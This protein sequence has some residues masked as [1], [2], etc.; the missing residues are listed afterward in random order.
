M[1]VRRFPSDHDPASLYPI[2]VPFFSLYLSMYLP[3]FS[4]LSFVYTLEDTRLVNDMTTCTY[5]SR[6]RGEE[7]NDENET[8]NRKQRQRAYFP[9][10]SQLWGNVPPISTIPCSFFFLVSLSLSLSLFLPIFLL[11]RHSSPFVFQPLF[12]SFFFVGLHPGTCRCLRSCHSSSC[13]VKSFLSLLYK[14]F[15]WMWHYHFG[16]VFWMLFHLILYLM[17]DKNAHIWKRTEHIWQGKWS[18]CFSM[19]KK[20][21]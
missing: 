12:L 3:F 20:R 17:S 7:E 11:L 18:P 2:H 19:E 5:R 15:V 10:G 21:K 13:G 8:G 14:P 1:R 16:V 9:S 6:Y 4:Q